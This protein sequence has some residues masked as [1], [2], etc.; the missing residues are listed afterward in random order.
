MKIVR[1]C[2]Y[3]IVI[4]VVTLTA[5]SAMRGNRSYMDIHNDVKA[6][7]ESIFS[8]LPFEDFL[9][10]AKYSYFRA[11][12]R[13]HFNG[14]TF[15]KDGRLMFDN[16]K[17]RLFINDRANEIAFLSSYLNERGTPFLYVRSPNK[18]QDNSL[19][20]IA[21]SGSTPISDGNLILEL[22]REQ[23]V[24]TFDLREQ[25]ENEGIDFP[26]A[27]FRGDHHWTTETTFWAF[28]Q[29]ADFVNREY[30]F[31][32]DEMSWDPQQYETIVIEYGFLGE[33]SK[34]VNAFHRFEDITALIP[35]F[36]TD[37]TVSNIID[38]NHKYLVSEGSFAEVFTPRFLDENITEIDYIDLNVV[39]RHFNRY[40]NNV[41][42]EKRKILLAM[43]S[44][45][46]PLASFFAVAFE[47]V[48]N[49]YIV[50]IDNNYRIWSAIDEYDYDLVIFLLS[51]ASANY[52]AFNIFELDRFFFGRP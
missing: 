26:S 28:G 29:I 6:G 24:D 36:P 32:I 22:L 14:V 46:I 13:G 52:E 15:L 40:E 44:M 5:I 18:L 8:P 7:I 20:P 38:S 33:E 49:L 43:D 12:N 50:N 9:Y 42:G 16:Q 11:T 45:G 17:E 37:F 27:F 3:F 31:S 51:D 10:E 35:K 21:F 2:F 34:A 48:D 30:G 25:M 23:G 1:G 4:T 19:L 39:N 41:A 47:T